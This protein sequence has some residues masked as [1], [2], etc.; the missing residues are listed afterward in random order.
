MFKLPWLK[1]PDMSLVLLTIIGLTMLFMM[2]F[3]LWSSHRG[4]H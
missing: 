4:V 1:A 3:E 2:T